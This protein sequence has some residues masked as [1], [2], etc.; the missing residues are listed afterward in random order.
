VEMFGAI[1]DGEFFSRMHDLHSP[2]VSILRDER[3]VRLQAVHV[4][5]G[6]S[7]CV[8]RWARRLQAKANFLPQI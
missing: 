7:S 6:S 2:L 4:E 5:T 3:N 8:L 1:L